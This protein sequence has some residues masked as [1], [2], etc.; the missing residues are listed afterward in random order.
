MKKKSYLLSVIGIMLTLLTGCSAYREEKADPVDVMSPAMENIVET[1]SQE[2]KALEEPEVPEYTIAEICAGLREDW[3]TW[4]DLYETTYSFWVTVDGKSYYYHDTY[5]SNEWTVDE[6]ADYYRKHWYYWGD[7]PASPYGEGTKYYLWTPDYEHLFVADTAEHWLYIDD[8]KA[9]PLDADSYSMNPKDLVEAFQNREWDGE[10]RRYSD[11]FSTYATVVPEYGILKY[12]FHT[13]YLSESKDPA[14]LAYTDYLDAIPWWEDEANDL[15]V[16]AMCSSAYISGQSKLNTP[17]TYSYRDTDEDGE[18]G[19]HS[20]NAWAI[21]YVDVPWDRQER[22]WAVHAAG[23]T[24]PG[25][26]T[27]E[28]ATH[29]LYAGR[30]TDGLYCV[31]DD[32]V[33]LWRAGRLRQTWNLKMTPD[34][35][36]STDQYYSDSIVAY[37]D[38]KL[39]ELYD[40]GEVGLILDHIVSVNFEYA[41]TFCGFTLSEDGSL[42]VCSIRESDNILSS[43]IA[44]DVV[45]ADLS[46]ELLV[47]YTDTPGKTY[48]VY[49]FW[50]S[51]A[52]MAALSWGYD[53]KVACLGEGS[54]GEFKELYETYE[55]EHEGCNLQEQFIEEMSAAYLA[56]VME[57]EPIQP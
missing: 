31:V 54:I 16:V 33:E 23:E 13:E 56:T 41:S 48:A 9:A 49:D 42:R 50:G 6:V 22:L 57:D 3:D 20:S 36:L 21:A 25:A 37:T 11:D 27:G 34:C 1:L 10:T 29:A 40:D 4:G 38:G 5:P 44:T 53:Y 51:D 7:D 39:Y 26:Y 30:T 18:S 28:Y 2:L 45:A 12:E 24:Y 8:I 17:S 14:G 43:E 35:Y 19:G 55:C 32:G 15:G 47:L 52:R 46:D